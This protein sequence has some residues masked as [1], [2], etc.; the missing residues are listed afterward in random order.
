[1]PEP[2]QE[3]DSELESARTSARNQKLEL[4]PEPESKLEP[5]PE[6]KSELE[7]ELESTKGEQNQHRVVV[8]RDIDDPNKKLFEIIFRLS[9]I[10][11]IT[12]CI[13]C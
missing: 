7:S 3:L 8:E 1:M 2:R 9:Y 12:V 5:K 13:Q 10:I 6:Q 4:K 11:T